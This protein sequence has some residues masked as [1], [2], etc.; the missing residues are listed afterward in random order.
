LTVEPGQDFS[1]VTISFDPRE[2]PELSARARQVAIERFGR[3]AVEAGWTFLTGDASAIDTLC[4]AVGF[5]YK[6]DE[7]SGQFAHASGVFVLT[8]DGILSRFL[9]GVNFS[10]RD[11]RLALVDA[12]S[13]NIGTAVDQVLLMCYMYD[14][15]TGK[16]GLAIITLIRIAGVATVIAMAVAIIIMLRRER[17]VTTSGAEV[18]TPPQT[19]L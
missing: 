6:Y 8:R 7:R 14:P 11:L 10:P 17:N 4:D 1:I 9:S 13:G 16:Y 2:G 5:R 18:S 12:S 15:I 3:G 19:S